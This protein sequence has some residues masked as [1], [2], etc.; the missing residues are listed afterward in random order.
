[1]KTAISIPNPLFEEVE[2]LAKRK[3]KSRSQLY[4]EAVADYLAKHDSESL[5]ENMTE[6]MNRVARAVDTRPDPWL[7]A[8]GRQVLQR[9]EG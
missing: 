9:D 5:T 7:A 3:G 6:R 2:R 1:M 4:S 8:A